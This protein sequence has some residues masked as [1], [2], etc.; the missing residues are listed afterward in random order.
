MLLL[1]LSCL[2]SLVCLMSLFWVS[3][4]RTRPDIGVLC[5]V[6]CLFVYTQRS[7]THTRLL[8]ANNDMTRTATQPATGR[9][10]P[11]TQPTAETPLRFVRVSES[12]SH[13]ACVCVYN[14]V[15]ECDVPHIRRR[16]AHTVPH[17]YMS[18]VQTRF[19]LPTYSP[20]HPVHLAVTDTH[21]EAQPIP[22]GV[23]TLT[24]TGTSHIP[25]HSRIQPVIARWPASPVS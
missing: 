24:D 21:T 10:Q 8:R 19:S 18:C 5:C 6:A 14:G 12:T 4:S 25:V 7:T 23:E 9:T 20:H 13:P 15:V 2:V 17:M 3:M 11:R 1:L 22:S 16:S